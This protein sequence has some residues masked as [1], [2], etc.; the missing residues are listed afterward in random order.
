MMKG[1]APYRSTSLPAHG[2]TSIE[3]DAGR[4]LQ[5]ASNLVANALRHAAG[6]V[7]TVEVAG[8]AW[9]VV[10]SVHNDGP[11]IP[12]ELLPHVFQPFRQDEGSGA[13]IGSSGL[14]LFIVREI[15]AAHD[16]TVA[17]TSN[18]ESGTTFTVRLPRQVSAAR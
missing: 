12:P 17:V 7:V 1:A 3:C 10:L 14:G 16:G 18:A 4:I 5:V 2:D 8:L 11:P 15:V 9:E 6:K 13:P